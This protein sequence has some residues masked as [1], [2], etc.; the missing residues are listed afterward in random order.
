MNPIEKEKKLLLEFA[1]SGRLP[2]FPEIGEGESTLG[3][4]QP[5]G[6]GE[7]D[8]CGY[9]SG[10]NSTLERSLRQLWKNEPEMQACIPVILAAVEK[11]RGRGEQRVEAAELYNYAM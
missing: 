7:P 10:E 2:G 3:P 9:F 1:G 4:A 11:S 6:K 5:M 8:L